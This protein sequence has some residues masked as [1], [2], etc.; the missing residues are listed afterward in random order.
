MGVFAEVVGQDDGPDL[1]LLHGGIGTGRYHWSQQ[2]KAFSETHR[3][4]LPDLPGHGRT[5]LDEGRAYTREVLAEAVE[6][7]L[8]GLPGPAPVMG[9]SMG[10]HSAM[11]LAAR[12]PALFG[13]LVLIGVS[14]RDHPGLRSWRAKFE[15]GV[16]AAEYPLWV[17][18]LSRIHTPLGGPDAWREVASRDSAG[19]AIDVDRDALAALDCPVLLVRGDSDSV[20]E[21]A[22]YAELR[23]LWPGSEELVVPAGGH[24][25]QI[26]RARVVTPALVDFLRR[27]QR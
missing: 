16:L 20:V 11:A 19:V 14:Y 15:P 24:D 7:Y 1:V 23:A 27:H 12:R 18:S 22:Q 13:A 17:R 8:E 9:F 26:T 25:C 10:G 21:P 4:H 2:V 5:P 6:A 3:V